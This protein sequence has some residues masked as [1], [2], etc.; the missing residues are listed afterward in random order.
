VTSYQKLRACNYLSKRPSTALLH[1]NRESRAEGPQW[2]HLDFGYIVAGAGD[3]SHSAREINVNW[4]ADRICF[5]GPFGRGQFSSFDTEKLYGGLRDCQ[6]LCTEDKERLMACNFYN[7]NYRGLLSIL[8]S[9]TVLEDLVLL[10]TR[11]DPF[12]ATHGRG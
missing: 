11:T 4:Q 9:G 3:F 6:R 1:T 12:P 8:P 5:M 10:N 7:F 2:Y